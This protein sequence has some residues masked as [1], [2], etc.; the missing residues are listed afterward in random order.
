MINAYSGKVIVTDFEQGSKKSSS[1]IY[2]GNDDGK[3]EGIRPRW[4][5]IHSVGEGIDLEPGYWVLVQH[6]RWTRGIVI[7]GIKYYMIDYPAG[8]LALS[9]DKKQPQVTFMSNTETIKSYQYRPE[10]FQDS[11]QEGGIYY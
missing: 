1:G 11:E 10:D 7:D 8:A 6:G 5:K 3:A 4:C 9:T 2:L